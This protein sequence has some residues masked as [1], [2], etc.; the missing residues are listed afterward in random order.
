MALAPHGAC[1]APSPAVPWPPR[2]PPDAPA[3]R[4]SP[5]PTSRPSRPRRDPPTRLL[6][7]ARDTGCLFSIDS[8]SHA[9]GQLDMLDYGCERAEEAGIDPD[10]IVN[11][12]SQ[13]RLLTW[14]NG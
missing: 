8:D 10:R 3:P 6:E 5:P 11:T 14:A 13:E 7:L 9:P 12:W 4:A 2:L 1:A